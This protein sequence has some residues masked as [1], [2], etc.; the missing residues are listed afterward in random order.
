VPSTRLAPVESI[1]TICAQPPRGK[2][3][4]S[5]AARPLPIRRPS[6]CGDEG[7]TEMHQPHRPPPGKSRINS[8][9][10]LNEGLEKVLDSLIAGDRIRPDHVQH[11]RHRR[12][13]PGCHQFAADIPKRQPASEANTTRRRAIT[14]QC[15]LPDPSHYLVSV[16]GASPRGVRELDQHKC[17]VRS[18]VDPQE[19]IDTLAVCARA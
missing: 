7:Q 1:P 8:T 11:R 16:P 19:A 18:H 14:A 6:G 4:R 2:S 17:V 3:R 10:V 5:T 9:C 13:I 12:H 15:S